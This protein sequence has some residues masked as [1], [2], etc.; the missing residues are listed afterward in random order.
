M[1]SAPKQW[2]ISAVNE[3]YT[4]CSSYPNLLV[5]PLSVSDSVLTAASSYR[6]KNRIPTLTY[7]HRRR[8]TVICRCAQPLAGVTKNTSTHDQMLVQAIRHATPGCGLTIIDARSSLAA[9]G[10]TIKGAGGLADA[11]DD[12]FFRDGEC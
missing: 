2:R 6:S 1:K 7:F 3:S 11:L 12:I 10:N 4:L 8:G 9:Q 5:F